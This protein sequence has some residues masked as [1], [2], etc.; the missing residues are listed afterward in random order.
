MPDRMHVKMRY[1]SQV[2]F[3]FDGT[4]GGLA[5]VYRVNNIYDPNETGTGHQPMG[6]D[7]LNAFYKR[8]L[9][10]G[11][12]VSAD[13][14]IVNTNNAEV[15]QCEVF[16]AWAPHDKTMFDTLGGGN[17]IERGRFKHRRL[18]TV[19]GSDAN[20]YRRAFITDYRSCAKLFGVKKSNYT[21][22]DYGGTMA[23]TPPANQ[24]YFL[25]MLR[26]IN[27]AV[28]P[29]YTNCIVNLVITYYVTLRDRKA[30]PLS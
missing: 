6:F 22:S 26:S 16:V 2:T 5:H 3:D 24:A 21:P 30:L 11:C 10:N 7:Q 19:H 4:N 25:V 8:Y 12:K 27:G 15:Q 1:F 17:M 13:F 20:K 29:N 9:V 23:G 14:E 18:W 28:V